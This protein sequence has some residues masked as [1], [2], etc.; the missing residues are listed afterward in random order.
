MAQ[1]AARRNNLTEI[2]AN[3][4]ILRRS[5]AFLIE[6]FHNVSDSSNR[7]HKSHRTYRSYGTY[8]FYS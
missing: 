5:H 6:L 8:G 1:G 7:T 2:G 4:A 3:E